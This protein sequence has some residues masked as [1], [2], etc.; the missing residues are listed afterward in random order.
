MSNISD[1]AK[2]AAAV[3]PSNT[4]DLSAPTRALFVGG[5]G[6]IVVDML[7]GTVTFK[8]VATGIFP[9]QCT[10]VRATGTTATDLIALW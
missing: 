6:D 10:R 9:I 3:T 7:N 2:Y 8:N 1:P 5:F 4:V